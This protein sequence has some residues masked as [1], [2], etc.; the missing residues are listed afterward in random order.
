M[1]D[2]IAKPVD[3]RQIGRALERWRHHI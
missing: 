1:D 3:A 2:Y